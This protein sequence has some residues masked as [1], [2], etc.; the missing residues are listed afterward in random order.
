MFISFFI[1]HI[2]NIIQFSSCAS[3]TLKFTT[4]RD[5]S[6]GHDG[7]WGHCENYARQ[8]VNTR[9]VCINALRR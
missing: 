2:Y 4:E 5:S 6:K 3:F 1:N 9:D 8:S 7:H